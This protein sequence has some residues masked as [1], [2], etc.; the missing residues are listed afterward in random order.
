MPANYIITVTAT[1]VIM[2]DIGGKVWTGAGADSH[3]STAANWTGNTVP[4]PGDKL[5]FPDVTNQV[6]TMDF[7]F[8]TGAVVSATSVPRQAV[9]LA[10][11]IDQAAPDGEVDQ[12][13]HMV[14]PMK[15]DVKQKAQGAASEVGKV[16]K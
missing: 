13:V 14:I 5:S 2:S 11:L 9:P 3:F 10:V 4:K 16:S 1:A 15:I 12:I 8:T 7:P 6:V